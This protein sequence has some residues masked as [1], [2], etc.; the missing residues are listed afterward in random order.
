MHI[1]QVFLW[2]VLSF[3]LG[4]ALGLFLNL[5]L[6]YLI[7]FLV[8]ASLTV[9]ILFYRHRYLPVILL[10]LIFLVIG[11][12]RVELVEKKI[13]QLNL[14][15]REFQGSAR[16]VSNPV[17]KSYFS[18][19]KVYVPELKEK[20]LVKL[21]RH[22][23]LIY[24]DEINLKTTLTIPENFD[25]FNYQMYLATK[26][27][28]YIGDKAEVEKIGHQASI[29]SILAGWRLTLEE[30][31]NL[32]IPAPQSAL[33][34]G[35]IFGGDDRLSE[36]LK[37]DFAKT[38]MTHI[39]AV[40]GYNVTIIALTIITLAI[41]L[42]AW[43]RQ[44]IW[45]AIGAVIFFVA[46]IGFPASGI[47][48]AIMGSLVLLAVVYGRAGNILGAICFS[49]AIMLFFNPLLLRYDVGFQLSFLAT[50]GIILIYPIFEKYLIARHKIFGIGEIIFLT[51]SAQ[52]FVLPIIIYNFHLLSTVSL[53][54]NLLILPIIP[55]TMLLVFLAMVFSFIFWPLAI[56]FSWGAYF[57]LFYEVKVVE[58]LADQNWSS[59]VVGEVNVLWYVI[60]Y[61][62]LIISL[63]IYW[64]NNQ[65]VL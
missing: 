7:F 24:G 5:N 39:V 36:D 49:A 29:L 18:T 3:I 43:R 17:R 58:L 50:I 11:F 57:L 54:A 60:Y 2:T 45:W 31:I 37:K 23:D 16:V 63:R 20:I 61:F 64:K 26:K 12:G 56:L 44:S 38:G 9:I 25:D 52:L 15:G 19:V 14:N 28:Y 13:A 48:A 22:S 47:R 27:I 10:S 40:S 51:I 33:A 41:F 34:N 46:I 59:V 55:L 30:Q 4:V 1:S 21:T 32:L 65:G 42:G 35:L 53:L 62:I 8:I 6:D